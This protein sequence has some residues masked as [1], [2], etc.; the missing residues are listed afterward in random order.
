[1]TDPLK[2]SQNFCS[3]IIM[4]L[5]NLHGRR[6]KACLLI[7]AVAH[8]QKKKDAFLLGEDI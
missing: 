2:P 7:D 1:M 4:L 5:V 8:Q 6:C 3:Y